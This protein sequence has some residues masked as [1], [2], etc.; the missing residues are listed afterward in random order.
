[1]ANKKNNIHI[2]IEG[3]DGVGKTTV[4]KLLAHNTG[5]KFIE[6]PLHYLF[7]NNDDDFTNYIKIRD[8]INNLEN[9]N[10][11]RAW[12][13]GLGNI[14]TTHMFDENIITDRH[15]LSNYFWCGDNET[16]II[17]NSLIKLIG[18]PDYTFLLIATPEEGF[19]RMRK[20]DINDSDFH[21]V[22]LYNDANNKMVSFLKDKQ[23][24]YKVIDTT[25]LTPQSIV[26]QIIST[27]NNNIGLNI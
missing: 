18:L 13:Y 17:F 12:F 19:M 7:D 3:M 10:V 22:Q 21:K 8:K 15:L 20:R 4:S 14:W 11:L 1:M 2:A 23:M 6:K 16:E 24:N 9:D 25:T 26:E 27:L 5:F